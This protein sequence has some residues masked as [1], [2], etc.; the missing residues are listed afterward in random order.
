MRDIGRRIQSYRLSRY[1]S[2]R[3]VALPKWAWL[4]LGAWL[5]WAGFGSDHSF[6]QLWR[7]ERASAR[8]R[9]VLRRT[10]AELGGYEKL[11]HDPHAQAREAEAHLREDEGWS[12]PNEIVFRIDDRNAPAP[13]APT[14]APAPAAKTK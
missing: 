11:A 3:G 6:Y 1:A 14:P 9:D 8:E 12:R 5:L 7:I 13:A 10:Q 2:N 4:V